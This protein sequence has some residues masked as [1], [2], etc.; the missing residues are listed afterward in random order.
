MAFESSVEDM[1]LFVK[2]NFAIADIAFWRQVM[3]SR[4]RLG[5]NHLILD[6]VRARYLAASFPRAFHLGKG[7]FV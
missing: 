3:I 5:D 1:L 4:E 2:T 7:S 6:S